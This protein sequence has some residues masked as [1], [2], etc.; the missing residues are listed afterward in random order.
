[1]IDTRFVG[2]DDT[3]EL[4]D[5]ISKAVE[6]GHWNSVLKYLD[7]M[8]KNDDI[9]HFESEICIENIIGIM[10]YG[11]CGESDKKLKKMLD[12]LPEKVRRKMI[13]VMKLN[14]E[15]WRGWGV[16]DDAVQKREHMIY[17]KRRATV[18]I[19]KASMK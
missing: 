9:H 15:N 14:P 10:Y 6:S 3:V 8:T 17:G 1:L 13:A 19:L 4:V 11:P 12:I 16:D 7:K 18:H 5:R 2:S